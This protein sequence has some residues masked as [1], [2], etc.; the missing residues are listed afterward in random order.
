MLYCTVLYNHKHIIIIEE[1]KL[2]PAETRMGGWDHGPDV[3]VLL[4]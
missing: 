2:S 4:T 3:S 1:G